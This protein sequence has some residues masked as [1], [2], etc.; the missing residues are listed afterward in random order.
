MKA[1]TDKTGKQSIRTLAQARRDY[2]LERAVAGREVTDADIAHEGQARGMKWGTSAQ[3]FKDDADYFTQHRLPVVR[4]YRE[5]KFVLNHEHQFPYEIRKKHDEPQKRAIGQL[6]ADLIRGA[7]KATQGV[8]FTSQELLAMLEQNQGCPSGKEAVERLCGKL[9]SIYDKYE[10]LCCLDSG[11]TT[12]QV[13]EVLRE[14]Y[15][16]AILP[17]PLSA[18]RVLTFL[19]N[20]TDIAWSLSRVKAEIQVIMLG[21]RLRKETQAYAGSMARA[22]IAA[23]N[24]NLDIVMV[25]C[26]GVK[27]SYEGGGDGG[28]EIRG[29]MSDTFEEAELKQALLARSLV[30]AVLI[31]SKKLKGDATKNAISVG[32]YPFANLNCDEVNLLITDS[33]RGIEA[34][35]EQC[36]KRGIAVLS[37]EKCL[38]A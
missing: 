3:S 30:K 9:R 27:R 34:E 13:A 18:L 8:Q 17:D 28:R 10:R 37:A 5:N 2:I 1:P 32:H 26:I 15:Q 23:W 14:G 12:L 7:T 35:V 25:G 4:V 29:F 24:M 19:T 6:A 36:A 21:G 38:K 20:S 31:D 16:G 22:C 33:T 11:T